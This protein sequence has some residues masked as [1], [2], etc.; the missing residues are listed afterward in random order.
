MLRRLAVIR[1]SRVFVAASTLG[2][3]FMM[4]PRVLCQADTTKPS[5][6]AI[7]EDEVFLL[8]PTGVRY[9]DKNVGEGETL[10]EGDKVTVHYR[11]W[12]LMDGILIYD[13]RLNNTPKSFAVGQIPKDSDK[14]VMP[15]IRSMVVGMRLHGVRKIIVPHH[16]LFPHVPDLGNVIGPKRSAVIEIEV[17]AASTMSTLERLETDLMGRKSRLP[18]KYKGSRES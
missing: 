7:E 5:P 4:R 1:W 14:S 16:T 8:L 12:R 2:T 13:S 6:A 17:V 11:L 3:G 15:A 18:N 9:L 10:E